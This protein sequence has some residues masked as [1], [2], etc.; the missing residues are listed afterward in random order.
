[1][2]R[3]K[4]SK[5]KSTKEE[6]LVVL[7]P[8]KKRATNLEDS[9]YKA[10][11]DALKALGMREVKTL[12]CLS[13]DNEETMVLM[14]G[15]ESKLVQTIYNAMKQDKEISKIIKHAVMLYTMEELPTIIEGLKDKLKE[16]EAKEKERVNNQGVLKNI[17]EFLFGK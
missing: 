13:D 3:P 9:R 11:E 5:N 6:E 16:E 8:K 4:G 12:F 14:N 10:L 2:G 15:V 1:M 17:K 7:D